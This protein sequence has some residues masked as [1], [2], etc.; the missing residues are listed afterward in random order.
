MNRRTPLLAVFAFAL[1]AADGRAS[2]AEVLGAGIETIEMAASSQ[3]TR[4]NRSLA[5][6]SQ[7]TGFQ[8]NLLAQIILNLS[9]RDMIIAAVA[10]SGSM[11]PYFHDNAL[12]L[13][14][15]APYDDLKLG[16]VVTFFDPQL[17]TI[18][19]HRLV[20]RRGDKFWSRGD[21]N[22]SMDKIYVTRENYRRRLAGVIYMDRPAIN[23]DTIA[24]AATSDEV[25]KPR[26]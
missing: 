18:I 3:V 5:P 23:G 20:E 22:S 1:C 17:K 19:V 16:D 12:L 21:H 4:T 11:R 14:E 9:G 6:S 2:L 7:L 24:R 25:Q 10:P 8:A 13:L 26:R 15:A